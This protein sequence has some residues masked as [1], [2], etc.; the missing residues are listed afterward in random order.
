M[1]KS[2]WP[3]YDSLLFLKDQM[4]SSFLADPLD[5]Q[6]QTKLE[7][8][9]NSSNEGEKIGDD[10]EVQDTYEGAQSFDPTDS[11]PSTSTARPRRGRKKKRKFQ[12]DS[13][14]LN[15]IDNM[16]AMIAGPQ[17]THDFP[18]KDIEYENTSESDDY[19]FFMSLIPHVQNFNSI[20]KLRLRNKIQ[21]LIIDEASGVN[22]NN[23]NNANSH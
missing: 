15:E 17:I 19:F 21:Q 4:I 14:S 23:S 22:I 9:E 10:S 12:D 2:T 18:R 13:E 7:V 6:P 20:Q 1:F 3:H 8:F 16:D 11:P 5:L